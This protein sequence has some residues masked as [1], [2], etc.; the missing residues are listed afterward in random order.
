MQEG[1]RVNT[2]QLKHFLAV[3]DAGT[4][5]AASE[6]AH[7]SVPA[8]SRSLR[9]LEA[10]LGVSLF[11]RHERRLHPTPYAGVFADRA[12]R[13]LFEEHEAQRSL[14]IMRDG[15][16]G[17]LHFG[18]GASVALSLLAPLCQT[19][20]EAAPAVRLETQVQTSA[21]LFESLLHERLDFFV[22]DVR[23]AAGN[24]D[25]RVEPLHRCRFAWYARGQH[26][27]AGTPGLAFADLAAY[28]LIHAGRA[29]ATLAHRFADLYDL[30]RPFV[31]LCS[32]TAGDTATVLTLIDN[33]DS[34]APLSDIAANAFA[35]KGRLRMLD[36]HPPMDLTLELGLIYHARRTLPPVANLAFVH[37]R[38]FF[39]QARAVR[40]RPSCMAAEG[41]A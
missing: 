7:L 21:T 33:T 1:Y 23:M 34:I 30:P 6:I 35:A 19:L 22:G 14:E 10:S 8:L 26:P 11:D 20:I 3:L 40:P 37:I 9:A 36:V 25:F 17:T 29:D 4:L 38:A 28:P 16:G 32:V 31:E 41:Q 5:A 13:M 2:R 18:M 27:L 24:A 39:A 15:S 12:R